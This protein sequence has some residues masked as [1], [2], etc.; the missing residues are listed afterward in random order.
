MTVGRSDA[1]NTWETPFERKLFSVMGFVP[2]EIRFLSESCPVR[3][4]VTTSQG[5]EIWEDRMS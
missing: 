4:A 1:A 5:A 3:A 2:N